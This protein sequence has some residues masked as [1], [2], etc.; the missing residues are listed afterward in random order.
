MKIVFFDLVSSFGGSQQLAADIAKRLSVEHDVEVIDVCGGCEP[1]V[2]TLED[3]GITVHVLMSKVVPLYIGC[4]NR[5]FRRLWLKICRMP[6][7]LQL[8][9]QLIQKVREINPDVIWTNSCKGLSFLASSKKI[10]KK[11][12]AFYAHGLYKKKQISRYGR[13]L[14]KNRTSKVAIF[15]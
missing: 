12:I 7:W 11:P 13:W 14:I 6:F 15:Q 3:A 9:R 2:K 8:Q 1:Y 10:S 4:Q 5:K